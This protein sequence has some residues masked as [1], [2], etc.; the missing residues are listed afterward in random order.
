MFAQLASYGAV[1]CILNELVR[2]TRKITLLDKYHPYRG[3]K[4]LLPETW[5]TA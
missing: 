4:N 1:K 3:R 5:E 2:S